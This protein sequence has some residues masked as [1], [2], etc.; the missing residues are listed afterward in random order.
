[1]IKMALAKLTKIWKNDMEERYLVKV[2]TKKK[3]K[4]LMKTIESWTLKT[5]NVPKMKNIPNR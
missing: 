4:G 1:M 5:N 3:K 2:T